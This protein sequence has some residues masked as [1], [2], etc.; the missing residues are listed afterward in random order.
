MEAVIRSLQLFKEFKGHIHPFQR[1]FDGLGAIIPGTLQCTGSKGIAAG[2]S[3]GMPVTDA[4]AKQI[5]H[6]LAFNFLFRTIMLEGEWIFALGTFVLN[7][8]DVCKVFHGAYL[9]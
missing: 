3:K 5:P 6:R 7:F 1:V 9:Y 4:E 2:S 8:R